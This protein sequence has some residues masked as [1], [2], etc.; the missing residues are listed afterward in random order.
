[1]ASLSLECNQQILYGDGCL[2]LAKICFS[3]FCLNFLR[4][5]DIKRLNT[6][7]RGTEFV[8]IHLYLK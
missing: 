1:M 6:E 4:F 2:L 3:L 8:K 5:G 7:I